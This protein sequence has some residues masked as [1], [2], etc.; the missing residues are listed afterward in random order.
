MSESILDLKNEMHGAVCVVRLAGALD[1][2]TTPSLNGELQG[3]I[4]AGHVKI[5][6]D[7]SRLEYIASAGIGTLLANLKEAR[8][9]G[10]E[11]RLAGAGKDVAD[12]FDL[13]GFTAAFKMAATVEE[14]MRDF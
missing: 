3:L 9:G 6:C 8:G 2:K 12:V 7:L 14:A 10:G 11:L 1:A 13:L 4:G 5:V